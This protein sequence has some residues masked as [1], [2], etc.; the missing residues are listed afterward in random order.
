[1]SI[2]LLKQKGLSIKGILF[3]GAENKD[4]E[5]IITDM[6]GVNVLGRIEEL[7][8]LNKGVISSIAQDLKTKLI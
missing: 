1:M 8:E 5:S 7:D 2:E 4:T 3:N 6:T